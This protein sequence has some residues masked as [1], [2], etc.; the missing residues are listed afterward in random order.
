MNRWLLNLA[1]FSASTVDLTA[2][3]RGSA[4]DLLAAAWD[5]LPRSRQR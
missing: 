2:W 3:N 4:D 1:V 5:G